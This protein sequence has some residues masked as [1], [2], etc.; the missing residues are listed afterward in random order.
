MKLLFIEPF[1]GGSHKAFADGLICNSAHS[2]DKVTLPAVNWNWRTRGAA[3][4]FSQAVDDFGKYDGIITTSLMRLADFR[5]F[6]DNRL[7]PV[8]VYFHENQLTY[9]LAPDEKRNQ[10]LCMGDISTALCADRIIFNSNFHMTSFFH[11]IE[12]HLASVPDYPPDWALQK[13]T[14][15]SNVIYPGCSFENVD[16]GDNSEPSDPPLIIWNHRWSYD[17]NAV[18]FFHALE[19][20]KKN[21]FRFRLAILGEDSD[22]IPEAF[23]NAQQVFKDEIVRCGYEEDRELYLDWLRK[24]DIVVSTAIQENFG[25]SIVEAIRYGCFPLLPD[26][27]SYPEIISGKFHKEVLYMSQ[28]DLIEKLMKILKNPHLYLNNSDA[29]AENINRYSWTNVIG[30]YDTAI[31]EMVSG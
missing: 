24:G 2:I 6:T 5:A 12:N 27:L 31:S 28:K 8:M 18:S 13:I 11:S 16:T 14:S 21:A 17:K 22:F 29:I 10:H 15:K 7:P 3:F 23:I 4:Y 19:V 1:Y 30:A 26:R 25:I 9:P 20:L